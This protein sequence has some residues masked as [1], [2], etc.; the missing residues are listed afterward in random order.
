MVAHQA[1]VHLQFLRLQLYVD[2]HSTLDEKQLNNKILLQ[3]FITTPIYQDIFQT[4]L[5]AVKSIIHDSRGFAIRRYLKTLQFWVNQ[6]ALK[7]I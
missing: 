5:R 6:T 2:L 3:L 1:D 4:L 7:E